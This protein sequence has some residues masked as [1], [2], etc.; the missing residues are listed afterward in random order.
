ME[1]CLAAH[2]CACLRLT[3]S[4]HALAAYGAEPE[5]RSMPYREIC[6]S[7]ADPALNFA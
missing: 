2:V 6:A 1:T 5:V 3:G 7:G 4:L